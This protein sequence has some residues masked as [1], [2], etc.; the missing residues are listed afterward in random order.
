MAGK[1][2]PGSTS[3]DNN[4]SY[5]TIPPIWSTDADSSVFSATRIELP[6]SIESDS[7]FPSPE[8]PAEED[9]P[10]HKKISLSDSDAFDTDLENEEKPV[11]LG[12]D[13]PAVYIDKCR[14]LG[15]VPA[16]YILRHIYDEKLNLKH[17]GIGPKGAEALALPLVT[18]TTLTMLNLEDNAIRDDGVVHIADMLSEN[19][20]ITHLNLAD[21]HFG[22]LGCMHLCD[23]LMKGNTVLK[24]NLAGNGLSD[25]DMKF[26]VNLITGNKTIK[27]LNLSRN[28]IGETSGK[29]LGAAVAENEH[30]ECLDLGWNN[31][32]GK[33]AALFLHGVTENVKLSELNL[34]WNGLTDYGCKYISECLAHNEVLRNFDI[35]ANRITLDGV[36]L[37]AKGLQVNHTLNTFRIGRNPIKPAGALE[38]LA[39]IEK[40]IETDNCGITSLDLTGVDVDE[41]FR[42]LH[43][44]ILLSR[45]IYIRHATVQGDFTPHSRHSATESAIRSDAA[46]IFQEHLDKYMKAEPMGVIILY[47]DDHEDMSLAK[48]LGS[49]DKDH[50]NKVT[51]LSLMEEIQV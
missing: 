50:A 38:I 6:S 22:H 29:I 37:I 10:D 20:Y 51:E 48:L 9:D 49:L 12:T 21:N 16:S 46:A 45:D 13:G 8:K 11:R 32:R 42:C 23:V 5:N 3:E 47:I 24:L 19:C 44:K 39:A 30:L 25:E 26:V 4:S 40:A 43:K 31:F 35:S 33:S 1:K 18:N 2:T 7:E 15:I 41:T 17:R 27:K 14:Q 28:N 34:S 36:H